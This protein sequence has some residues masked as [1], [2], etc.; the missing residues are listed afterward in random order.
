MVFDLLDISNTVHFLSTSFT[1]RL[2][3]KVRGNQFAC[4]FLFREIAAYVI[5]VFKQI[6][7]EAAF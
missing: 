2:L 4:V 3:I 6:R 5:C 7:F 1:I